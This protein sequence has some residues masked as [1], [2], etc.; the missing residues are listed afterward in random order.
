ME[1]QYCRIDGDEKLVVAITVEIN[2]IP[3]SENF[4]I[5]IRWVARADGSDLIVDIGQLVIFKKRVMMATKIQNGTTEEMR[6]VT[7]SHLEFC[8]ESCENMGGDDNDIC[9][10]TSVKTDIDLLDDDDDGNPK[11]SN[12][13][14]NLRSGLRFILSPF[15]SIFGILTHI[16]YTHLLL[17]F[18]LLTLCLLLKG[19][20]FDRQRLAMPMTMNCNAELA[21]M[22]YQMK[23]LTD[24]IKQI[25]LFLMEKDQK[26]NRTK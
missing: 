6:P 2:G 3:F 5:E 11:A 8:R 22:S 26:I 18:I 17:I 23:A 25:R 24:E 16:Q 21:E 10:D 1:T 19:S 14:R 9:D 13:H 15:F 12:F 4:T 7:Q 20:Y